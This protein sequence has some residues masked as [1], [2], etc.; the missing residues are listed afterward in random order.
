ML[1]ESY[2]QLIIYRTSCPMLKEGTTMTMI[3]AIITRL[4]KDR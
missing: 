1:N 3:P 2:L 4:L